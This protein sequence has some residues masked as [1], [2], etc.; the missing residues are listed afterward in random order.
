MQTVLFCDD[1]TKYNCMWGFFC[2][3]R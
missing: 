2:K 1:M 3:N